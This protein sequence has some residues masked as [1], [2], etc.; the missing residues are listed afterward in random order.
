MAYT[1]TPFR[2]LYCTASNNLS[3]CG[4]T[5]ATPIPYPS[6][7]SYYQ[8]PNI[9]FGLASLSGS[10]SISNVLQWLPSVGVNAV[11][12]PAANPTHAHPMTDQWYTAILTDSICVQTDSIHVSVLPYTM[13]H[14]NQ[15]TVLCSPSPIR[16]EAHGARNYTWITSSGANISTDSTFVFS[17]LRTTAVYLYMRDVNGLTYS[18]T[19]YITVRAQ[20][21]I[22]PSDT[23]LPW[24]GATVMVHAG[25]ALSYSW[26]AGGSVISTISSAVIA[27]N[28]DID[29][30][31]NATTAGC[32][33]TD[34][35]HIRLLSPIDV[36]PGDANYDRTTSNTDIL[37]I[38]MAYGYVGSIRPAASLIWIA[39]PVTPWVNSL[40]GAVNS[41]HADCDGNGTVDANDTLAVYQNYGSVHPKHNKQRLGQYPLYISADKNLYGPA[42]TM[43]I[44]LSLT[45][46]RNLIQ[47]IYGIAYSFSLTS[48]GTSHIVRMNQAQSWMGRGLTFERLSGAASADLAQSRINHRDT[49]G[50]GTIAEIDIVNNAVLNAIDSIELS[51]DGITALTIHGDTVDFTVLPKTVTVSKHPLGMDGVN[52]KVAIDLYP[53]PNTG[54]FKVVQSSAIKTKMTVS[55]DL[56]RVVYEMNLSDKVATVDLGQVSAGVYTVTFTSAQLHKSKRVMVGR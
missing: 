56:G 47:Q 36:W 30:I 46:G 24:P 9:K 2:S 15:D 38:G 10:S 19:T 44:T 45:D 37:A 7:A 35:C 12:N 5:G 18:D 13:R 50:Y 6:T 20:I 49:A 40:P 4:V 54:S 11:T 3:M 23:N 43:H 52:E 25:P 32:S 51:V 14:S 33:Y 42:D 17:P 29:I 55:D 53:N 39:Q 8:R 48:A 31:L 41:A 22:S 1:Q 28:R 16:L 27:V 21:S 26:M 34:T